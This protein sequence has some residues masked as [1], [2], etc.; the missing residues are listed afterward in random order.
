METEKND[1]RHRNGSQSSPFNDY[2]G[3]TDFIK[4]W[5]LLDEENFLHND[6]RVLEKWNVN[7]GESLDEACS[8]GH[9]I[10]KNKCQFGGEKRKRRDVVTRI[11]KEIKSSI[12]NMRVCK[13][14]VTK[15]RRSP[16]TVILR[17]ICYLNLP[18]DLTVSACTTLETQFT[19]INGY[20]G[21]TVYIEGTT[22][23]FDSCHHTL[24]GNTADVFQLTF[25]TCGVTYGFLASSNTI[26]FYVVVTQYQFVNVN[27]DPRFHVRC[28]FQ[29]STHTADI[30][31]ESVTADKS[32]TEKRFNTD[33]Y[34]DISLC[35]STLNGTCDPVTYSNTVTMGDQ[36]TLRFD[37]SPQVP[38][39]ELRVDECF[40]EAKDQQTGMS[41]SMLQL[42]D[43]QSH[44]SEYSIFPDFVHS[45]MTITSSGGNVFEV[46]Y[47]VTSFTAF[48]P[49]TITKALA[50]VDLDLVIGCK[51]AI[52]FSGSNDC[53]VPTCGG[54]RKKRA[55]EADSSGQVANNTQIWLYEGFK[56]Q[57][58]D[59]KSTQI[60]QGTNGVGL[61]PV[62]P[63]TSDICLN[64]QEFWGIL[65]SLLF[66]IVCAV[67]GFCCFF[68]ITKRQQRRRK[69]I[70]DDIFSSASVTKTNSVSSSSQST[71]EQPHF[72]PR[73]VAYSLKPNNSLKY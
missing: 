35:R 15:N 19:V 5:R 72:L 14:K 61:L 16:I 2:Y 62:E 13:Y 53:T 43:I 34:A 31:V 69:L 4:S 57:I 42:L 22:Q 28:T 67:T 73:Y 56:M 21:G 47:A 32:G 36:L 55:D 50:L 71:V 60:E 20:V 12:N 64:K 24:A 3:Y 33:S 48:I 41:V 17:V 11:G 51:V 49:I 27:S 68:V 44:C 65:L 1:F 45:T 46:P 70:Y 40:F 7:N 66:L 54:A 26:D 25:E 52:C 30:Q 10:S 8:N 38:N 39:Y 37:L 58:G 59:H 23:N 9:S 18:Q 29:E 63:G 6:N